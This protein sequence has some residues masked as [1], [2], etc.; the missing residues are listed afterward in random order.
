MTET[1]ALYGGSFDPPHVA[2]TLVAA[3]ATAS[4]NVDRVLVVPTYSH[5]FGKESVAFEHRVAMCRLAMADLRSAEVSEVER[6]LAHSLTYDTLRALLQTHPD[7]QFRLLIGS[8]I[9]AGAHRWHRWDDVVA[10]A[11]P[12]IIGR[13]GYD[14]PDGTQI[15]LPGVSSTEIRDRIRRGETTEGLLSPDVAAYA[16]EH[17]LY[18]DAPDE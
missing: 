10:M 11:P 16:N 12:M 17:G 13:A 4:S 7:A 9:L 1:I 14:A 18:T 5:A 15:T 3:W 8:D 2:H 6:E